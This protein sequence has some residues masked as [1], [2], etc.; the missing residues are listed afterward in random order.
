MAASEEKIGALIVSL[1]ISL[2]ALEQ[3]LKDAKLKIEDAE[4][5]M[6]SSMDKVGDSIASAGR[7]IRAFGKEWSMYITAPIAGVG[8]AALKAEKD[9]EY[10]LSKMTGIIGVSRDQV[11]AWRDDLLKMAGE[12][13]QTPQ[14]L[15]EGLFFVTSAGRIGAETLEIL[16]QSARASAFGL[17]EVKDIVN[18]TVAALNAYRG[19]GLRA[20]DAVDV[21]TNT[22][23]LGMLEMKD[24][25]TALGIAFP[26]ATLLGLKFHEIGAAIASMTITGTTVET[27]AVQLRQILSQLVDPASQAHQA[28]QSVGFSAVEFR[29]SIA[30][31]GLFS[32]L[33][34][35][36]KYIDAYGDVEKLGDIFGN[37]RAL[38]AV[39]D[40]TGKNAEYNATIF[41]RMADSSGV[42]KRAFEEISNTLQFKMNQVMADWQALLIEIGDALKDAVLPLL[43]SLIDK[44]RSVTQW[45][46]NLSSEEQRSLIIKAAMVAAIGPLLIVLGTML[47]M[48][49]NITKAIYGMYKAF[50][51]LKTAVA[52]HPITALLTIIAGGIATMAIFANN[53]RKV[54]EE[55]YKLG[56]NI[57]NVNAEIGKLVFDEVITQKI[58]EFN[59]TLHGTG[60]ETEAIKE[61]PNIFTMLFAGMAMQL[62]S[63]GKAWKNWWDQVS[64]KD[65]NWKT[66]TKQLVQDFIDTN[67]ELTKQQINIVDVFK[68]KMPSLSLS[69]LKA[70]QEYITN[71]IPEL[72]AAVVRAMTNSHIEKAEQELADFR[73]ILSMVR[74]EIV[75][76][77]KAMKELQDPFKEIDNTFARIKN[78]EIPTE[79]KKLE[80]Q[81]ELAALIGAEFDLAGAKYKY[82]ND[83]LMGFA[84]SYKTSHPM[85]QYII[86]LI[87]KID[88]AKSSTESLYSEVY[89]MF[90]IFE[91]LGEA[92]PEYDVAAAKLDYVDEQITKLI[93]DGK[94]LSDLDVVWLM[95]LKDSLNITT[96]V[97]SLDVLKSTMQELSNEFEIAGTKAVHYGDDFDLVGAKLDAVGNLIDRLSNENIPENAAALEYLAG[98]YKKLRGEMGDAIDVSELLKQQLGDL[99]ASTVET[100]FTEVDSGEELFGNLLKVLANFMSQLGKAMIMIGVARLAFGTLWANPLAV[101]AAG[102]ALVALSAMIGNMFKQG[103]AAE[104]SYSRVPA[105]ANGGLVYGPTVG[106]MGEYPGASSNPE[107]ISPLSTLKSLIS[108]S[109]GGMNGKVEFEIA[110]EVIHGVL[111]RY[112]QKTN[113]YR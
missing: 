14:K 101:I 89:K 53:T 67:R 49:G 16:D 24:L 20:A 71:M 82:L 40:M 100:L 84:G 60:Q 77:E 62:S 99:I 51:V 75:A 5:A 28:L 98:W 76:T 91:T 69:E 44:L 70:L 92:F 23:R 87:Q 54:A 68:E 45:F 85:M 61:T 86:S 21:L 34:K 102:S 90:K 8:I 48:I 1:G 30:N 66:Q 74:S 96:T 6:K 47:S 18:V 10:T 57:K 112:N 27:S 36:R 104:T 19:S 83:L 107:V 109:T 46:S 65:N 42:A 29:E 108:D 17:G 55:Q 72:E 113:S 78:I 105:F 9:F 13:G 81:A 32:A 15:A 50:L 93:K 95:G 3:G 111:K 106:L 2:E 41:E 22:V 63:T 58:R 43:T 52:T 64:G 11:N 110:G 4:K 59:Q 31:E 38:T 79:F 25:P 97:S 80:Q 12:V 7:K 94:D 39:L 37:V 35:L 33:Q 73:N 56:Q 26:L 103:P 88:L